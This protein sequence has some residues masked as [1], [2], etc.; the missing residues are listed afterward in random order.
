LTSV[1]SSLRVKNIKDLPID[2]KDISGMGFKGKM[3]GVILNFAL[4]F[5]VRN[6]TKVKA[7]IIN[8]IKA[9]YG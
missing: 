1:L 9:E 5:A 6:N 8:A 2:G 3:I 7:K 4:E